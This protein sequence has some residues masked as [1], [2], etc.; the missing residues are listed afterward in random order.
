MPPGAATP[1]LPADV[2][3]RTVPQL[4]Q[5][6]VDVAPERPATIGHSLVEGSEVALSYA[7]LAARA[8]SLASVFGDRVA[9][10]LG[11]DGI[12]EAHVAYHAA[13]RAGAINVPINTFYKGGELAYAI[14]AVS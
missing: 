11:N 5:A 9:I 1:P 2:P 14:R 3:V 12:I 8:G 7:E 13:H 6:A 4:L 10:V